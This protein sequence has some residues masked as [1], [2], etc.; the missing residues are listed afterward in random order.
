M[1]YQIVL[2]EGLGRYVCISSGHTVN[3]FDEGSEY[4]RKAAA[5]FRD[6]VSPFLESANGGLY[7]LHNDLSNFQGLSQNS[8][9]VSVT[10]FKPK[11]FASHDFL[12]QF[13]KL[14][15]AKMTQDAPPATLTYSRISGG[16][17]R[18]LSVTP[19]ENWA[20][21]AGNYR[22]SRAA[23]KELGQEQMAE[24]RKALQATIVDAAR[25]IYAL[26]PELSLDASPPEKN[27]ALK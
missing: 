23:M 12:E 20:T 4:R 2:G 22:K 15:K 21:A 5:H 1:T 7:W 19:F 27:V 25:E 9:Y 24:L 11:P 3:D 26:R 16:N 17:A 13:A 18:V 10:I 14:H 6:N 8:P